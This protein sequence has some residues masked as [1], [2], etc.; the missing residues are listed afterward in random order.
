V[1]PVCEELGI[2]R[3]PWSPL[4][5]GFLTGTIGPKTQ[6]DAQNDV[7]LSYKLPRFTAGALEAN[8]PIF[9]LLADVGRR[10]QATSGQAALAWLL[11]RMS[12]IVPVPGT[13][14]LEQQDQ[15]V[16]SLGV[17]ISIE[18]RM[19][20]ISIVGERFPPAVF[21]LSDTGARVG[22]QCGRV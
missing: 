4:G 7:R 10:H 1:I 8:Q 5:P 16:A 18:E 15:N 19:A 20:N 6:L 9:E 11:A 13:T 17:R 14:K 21:A 22:V 2:G 12:W 3:S